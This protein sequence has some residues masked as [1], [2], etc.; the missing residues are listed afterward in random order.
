VRWSHSHTSGPGR[1]ALQPPTTT[2]PSLDQAR[3]VRLKKTHERRGGQDS[4]TSARVP[5]QR[6]STVTLLLPGPAPPEH[7]SECVD[8]SP[9]MQVTRR[10]GP[11]MCPAALSSVTLT[12]SGSLRVS[13]AVELPLQTRRSSIE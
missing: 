5:L 4:G 2:H 1:S 9:S 7:T 6:A 10:A 12:G 11:A 3:V 13:T 8:T